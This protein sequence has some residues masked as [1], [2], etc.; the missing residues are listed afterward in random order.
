[1]RPGG[2][3][4][5]GAAGPRMTLGRALASEAVRM[6]RSALLPLHAALALA[7]GGAAGAYFGTTPWD[8]HLAADAFFQLLGAGA[9]LLAGISCGLAMDAE[10]AA[11]DCAQLLGVASRRCALAAK[12]VVL[13]ALGVFAAAGAA[14]A[15]CAVMAACGRP[16]PG[17]ASV[18]A[19]VLGM[20]AGSA[21]LY[22][23]A[24]AVALR[25]GRNA[26]I[27]LGALGLM[28]AVSSMGGLANGLVTGTLSGTFG[29]GAVAW[30]PFAW[31]ARLSSIA[32]ELGMAGR[33]ALGE[34]V[35]R[36]LLDALA[37]LAVPCAAVTLALVAL[38]L[39]GADRFEDARRSGE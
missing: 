18:A 25:F 20:G 23:I 21:A 9:P 17:A 34:E 28:V 33:L 27:G 11:G 8:P 5:R 14:A 4:G 12:A 10:R 38:A 35:V 13:L 15:F 3:R 29:L 2:Y 39:A 37:T 26:A 36:G 1:M 24:L 22:V 6:R 30:V 7:L 32:I 31:P 19:A 16:V